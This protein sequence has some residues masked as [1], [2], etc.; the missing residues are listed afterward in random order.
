MY[1][2]TYFKNINHYTFKSYFVRNLSGSRN[3]LEIKTLNVDINI[4][5]R[6]FLVI[7]KRNIKIKI[8]QLPWLL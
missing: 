2:I 7:F 3:E 8:G 6:L 1:W 5:D 4:L